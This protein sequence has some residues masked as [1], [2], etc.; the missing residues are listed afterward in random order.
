VPQA[1]QWRR[2]AGVA[3]TRW[4]PGPRSRVDGVSAMTVRRE[5]SAPPGP[6]NPD[7]GRGR[8]PPA[9]ERRRGEAGGHS[10]RRRRG[11]V[12]RERPEER[13]SAPLGASGGNAI[14]RPTLLGVR[15]PTRSTATSTGEARPPT[16]GDRARRRSSQLGGV[17]EAWGPLRPA[18]AAGPPAK[19]GPAV[20]AQGAVSQGRPHPRWR[21]RP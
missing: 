7:R 12:D 16:G 2:L 18:W 5:R 19:K 21:V 13:G 20:A 4:W 8:S 1:T 11:R 9:Q 10:P 14:T 17:H 15:L 6:P 3:S